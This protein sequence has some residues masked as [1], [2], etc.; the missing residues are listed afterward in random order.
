MRDIGK[1]GE[2]FF[3]AWCA[4]AG[5][6]ANSSETDNNGWDVLVEIDEDSTDFDPLSMHEGI[7]ETKVQIKSTD[8]T[9]RAVDVE[10]SNLKKMATSALASFYVL[11]EFGGGESP[12]KAYLRH[13]DV[14][15]SEKI[16]KRISE[17]KNENKNVELNK[18]KMRLN[19]KDEILPLSAL[20]LKAMMLSYIGPS[21][22]L[23]AESKL[24]HLKSVGFEGGRYRL[25]FSIR[26]DE[27]LRKLIDISLGKKENIEVENVKSFTI[28]FGAISERTELKSDTA[29]LS[30]SDIAP[31]DAGSLVFRD[32]LTGRTM[33]FPT[34]LYRSPLNSWVSKEFR[35]VRIVAKN[36]ELHM[37]VLDKTFSLTINTHLLDGFSVEDALRTYKLTQMFSSPENIR[38]T[39]NFDSF[40]SAVN[41]QSG[42]SFPD[43][44]AEV[45]LLE[46]AVRIKNYFELDAPLILT[47]SEFGKIPVQL[48]ALDFVISNKLDALRISFL[49]NDSIEPGTSMDCFCVCHFQ[50]GGYVF[51]ELMLFSGDIFIVESGKFAIIPY[52]KKSIYKT[53]EGVDQIDY[54]VLGDEIASSIEHHESSRPTVNLAFEFLEKI[55][56]KQQIKPIVIA[57]I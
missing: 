30:M 28:R 20:N 33:T 7:I 18:K 4:A 16:L 39:F 2:K 3:G 55:R 19:F 57:E 21:K 37:G 13:V 49:S 54:V 9:K 56:Q 12:T 15:L 53:A 10:L 24:E 29:V 47:N 14:N 41:L 32:R 35:K 11:L 6:T 22:T 42:E 43:C 44:A 8:G 46:K 31:S 23:Y 36:F 38:I 48:Q 17:L 5:M 26:G 25:E 40:T 45:E 27:Q 52:E 51:V 50:M 34:E 1:A